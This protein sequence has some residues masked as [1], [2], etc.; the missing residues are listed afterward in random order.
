[1]VSMQTKISIIFL[2]YSK[3]ILEVLKMKGVCTYFPGS[4]TKHWEGL[5]VVELNSWHF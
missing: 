1:M 2:T 3:K 4:Q 5:T